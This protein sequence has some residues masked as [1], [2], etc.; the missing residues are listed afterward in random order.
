MFPDTLSNVCAMHARA[1]GSVSSS[2]KRA[3]QR[4]LTLILFAKVACYAVVEVV[5]RCEESDI[6]G[7]QESA[8]KRVNVMMQKA[9]C[10]LLQHANHRN[11]KYCPKHAQHVASNC[12]WA[13]ML[14]SVS[15]SFETE[16]PKVEGLDI[17]PPGQSLPIHLLIG[18]FLQSLP[19][20]QSTLPESPK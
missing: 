15:E 6:C 2:G 7:L 1:C 9:S 20:H 13:D 4:V 14:Q 8:A 3:Y 10:A 12:V 18:V 5:K 16:S 11:L 17:L 19:Y